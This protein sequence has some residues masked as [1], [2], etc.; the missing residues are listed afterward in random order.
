MIATHGTALSRIIAYLGL[1]LLLLFIVTVYNLPPLDLFV[2][3]TVFG[4]QF[5]VFG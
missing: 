1:I 5:S 4:F 3:N 2:Y